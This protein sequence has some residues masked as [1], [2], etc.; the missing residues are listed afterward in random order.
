MA[1]LNHN[2]NNNQTGWVGTKSLLGTTND[3]QELKTVTVW[4]RNQT[5]LRKEKLSVWMSRHQNSFWP[6]QKNSPYRLQR[7]KQYEWYS[8][9]KLKV[10]L[11]WDIENKSCLAIWLDPKPVFDHYFNLKNRLWIGSKSKV[12]IEGIIE[13][14]SWLALW[15]DYKLVFEPYPTPMIPQFDAKKPKND[16]KIRSKLKVRIEVENKN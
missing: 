10:R 7:A 6:T 4:R 8:M 9:S 3:Q 1:Q 11:E 5:I 15:V 14:K 2:P 12:R 16:I 13:N